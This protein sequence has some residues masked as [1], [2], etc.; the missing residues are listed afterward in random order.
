MAFHVKSCSAKLWLRCRLC[1]GPSLGKPRRQQLFMRRTKRQ[2]SVSGSDPL[3]QTN[4]HTKAQKHVRKTFT[5]WENR[6]TL[7]EKKTW[8]LIQEIISPRIQLKTEAPLS[9]QWLIKAA[10]SAD[11]DADLEERPAKSVCPLKFRGGFSQI[12][13]FHFIISL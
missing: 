8:H 1:W 7:V 6:L 4:T 9:G 12:N 2:E 10:L 11:D 3:W 13:V 5:I